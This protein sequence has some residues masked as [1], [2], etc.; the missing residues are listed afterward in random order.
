MLRIVPLFAA[1]L[2][3]LAAFAVSPE[4]PVSAP[5]YGPTP[6]EQYQPAAA[7]DGTNYL[8][9]WNET[10]AATSALVASRIAANGE[11]LD[12]RGITISTTRA[13][14]SRPHVA[15]NGSSYIVAWQ[16][17]LQPY[18]VS[19]AR[20]SRDG[21]I[22]GAPQRLAENAILE[23]IAANGSRVVVIYRPIVGDSSEIRSAVLDADA[24]VIAT[25]LLAPANGVRYDADVAPHRD[26]WAVVWNHND[27]P[28][29][30]VDVVR[31]DANGAS[32]DI[33]P[34]QITTG[35]SP[36]IASDGT[37]LVI[38]AR[39]GSSGRL[40]WSSYS[41]TGDLV[42]VLGPVELPFS[43]TLWHPSLLWNGERYLVFA[44]VFEESLYHPALIQLDRAGRPLVTTSATPFDTTQDPGSIS[45]LAAN[46]DVLLTW[47]DLQ[48]TG[49]ASTRRAAGAVIS[50]ATLDQKSPARHFSIVANHQ[51]SPAAASNGSMTVVAWAESG[52]IY[53]A[54]IR[55]GQ[56]LDG[57][58][59]L[60]ATP[61]Y[62]NP[63]VAFDGRQFV[64]ASGKFGES[65]RIRFISPAEGLLPESLTITETLRSAVSVASG[66]GKTLLLWQGSDYRAHVTPIDAATRMIAGPPVIVSPP[67]EK[68]S[69]PVA[70]WNG[71]EFLVV[72]DEL[73][74]QT[75]LYFPYN[76][77]AH[78]RVKAARLS[79][80]LAL[81]DPQ[82]LL[83]GD[84]EDRTD[85]VTSVVSNGTGWLVAWESDSLVHTV[86]TS[87]VQRDGTVD[88]TPAGTI[89]ATGRESKAVWDGARY[90]IAWK[91][92]DDSQ[93]LLGDL[94][95]GA[96]VAIAK[97]DV[98]SSPIALTS[99]SFQQVAVAY[100]RYAPEQTYGGVNRI[101]MRTVTAAAKSR[102]VR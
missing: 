54:R 69:V 27:L 43:L 59:V 80:E 22:L 7:T 31:L 94:S 35:Y 70:A 25:N 37:D 74:N 14:A 49:Q 79:G 88:G 77:L 87:R 33:Q 4:L 68:A 65:A 18:E 98:Y 67:N 66:G 36:V 100:A 50:A 12:P 45:G 60:I 82:P 99:P 19:I 57:R 63:S 29:V 32:I 95:G 47:I 6:F 13:Y 8:A 21:A 16:T 20:I 51:T 72:W 24:N 1:L 11:V 46:G 78:T 39:E 52:G 84:V 75:L 28:S 56:P 91:T 17:G 5:V 89:V 2:I 44:G 83:I 15:W 53:A 76:I 23:D 90:A 73:I 38:V 61:D 58:G 92:G 26:G 41:V 62:T 86:R 30:S 55:N 102:A 40:A 93:I 71:S 97:T 81:R 96:P 64:V 101:F 3:S 85:F 48:S 10:R 9:V 34:R 42:R